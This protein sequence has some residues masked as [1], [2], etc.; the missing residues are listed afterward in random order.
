MNYLQEKF[1]LQKDSNPEN[2]KPSISTVH[3]KKD[4]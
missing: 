1:N 2:K 4:D 3:L